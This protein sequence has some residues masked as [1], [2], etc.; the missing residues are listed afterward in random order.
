MRYRNGRNVY[1]LMCGLISILPAGCLGASRR[2]A[3]PAPASTQA[4][5]AT[6]PV[7]WQ[8]P[9][10]IRGRERTYLLHL[11]A[12]YDSRKAVPLVLVFHGGRGSGK[13]IARY[14]GFSELAD[15]KGFI[16]VYPDAYEGHWNDGRPARARM[17]RRLTTWPS[18]RC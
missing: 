5:Q 18:S 7:D 16:V 6:Q 10:E 1:L 14:S 12:S 15:Q 3:A 13:Q 17:V 4:S 9:I 8:G 11:P 2:S